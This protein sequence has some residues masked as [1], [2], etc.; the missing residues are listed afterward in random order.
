MKAKRLNQATP[1]A[2]GKCGV[3]GGTLVKVGDSYV[4]QDTSKC[5]LLQ[6]RRK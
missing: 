5:R 4:H 6:L 3:A 2:C 1:I